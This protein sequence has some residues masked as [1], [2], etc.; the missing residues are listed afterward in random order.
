MPIFSLLESKLRWVTE[1]FFDQIQLN[2]D[3]P[4]STDKQSASYKSQSPEQ[5]LEICFEHIKLMLCSEGSPNLSERPV[6]N[7]ADSEANDNESLS[8]G[9]TDPTQLTATE[10]HSVPSKDHLLFEQLP[11]SELISQ[12][13]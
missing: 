1:A 5:M 8:N 10:S 3:E 11:L 7:A 6:R 13:G 12:L 4:T 9:E 2:L